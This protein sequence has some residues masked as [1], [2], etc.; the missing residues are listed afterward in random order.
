MEKVAWVRGR[1]IPLARGASSSTLRELETSIKELQR[2][3]VYVQD[4]TLKV[5]DRYGN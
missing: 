3:D 4:D 5:I 1:Y 2:I